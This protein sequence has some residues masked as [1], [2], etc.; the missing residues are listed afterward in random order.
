[1]VV[2]GWTH[3]AADQRYVLQLGV[4]D[5]LYSLSLR[6]GC[7]PNRDGSLSGVVYWGAEDGGERTRY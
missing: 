3:P 7:R 1:M 6:V 2:R 4:L 5:L